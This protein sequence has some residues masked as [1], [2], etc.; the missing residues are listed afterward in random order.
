MDGLQFYAEE[1]VCECRWT[2]TNSRWWHD[3]GCP[4]EDKKDWLPVGPE[5]FS[6]RGHSAQGF[7]T[8]D[9][10]SEPLTAR[11]EG[12]S[13]FCPSGISRYLVRIPH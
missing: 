7:G 6:G 5:G 3:E 12:L 13:G 2:R 1:A 11:P 10:D 9:V 4:A 8:G